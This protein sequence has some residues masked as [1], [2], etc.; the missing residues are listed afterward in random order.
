MQFP[1][2]TTLLI[3]A[4]A[5]PES[6]SPALGPVTIDAPKTAA[7]N[8][9]EL[10]DVAELLPIAKLFDRGNTPPPLPSPMLANYREAG[11]AD[12]IVP[13]HGDHFQVPIVAVNG[14]I[15]TGVA[16]QARSLFPPDWQTLPVEDR[17]H[18]N[19][20]SAAILIRYSAFDYYTGGDLVGV[21]LD[22][23]PA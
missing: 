4:G 14:R 2:G 22:G 17:P 10:T 12:Q 9:T 1:D 19:H 6:T 23:A 8:L 20:F 15:C 18:E 11:R 5:I 13:L 3:D 7:Y 16:N 21:P